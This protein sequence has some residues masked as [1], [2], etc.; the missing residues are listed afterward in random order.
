[1]IH[2]NKE[3]DFVEITECNKTYALDYAQHIREGIRFRGHDFGGKISVFFQKDRKAIFK[4]AGHNGVYTRRRTKYYPPQ[5][6]IGTLENDVFTKYY[7]ISYTRNH[8]KEAKEKALELVEKIS[9]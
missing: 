2:I 9:H 5:F 7:E 4:V 6:M 1:M 3:H 8:T